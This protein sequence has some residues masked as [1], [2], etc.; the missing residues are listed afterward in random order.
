MKHPFEWLPVS[1][2]KPVFIVLLIVTLFIT[3]WT[4]L[5]NAPLNNRDAPL[6]IISYEFAFT[7]DNARGIITSWKCTGKLYAGISLGLDFI[8]IAG[9]M[10]TIGLGCILAARF[11][12]QKI[13]FLYST[14]IL[15]SWMQLVAGFLDCIE[16]AALLQVLLGSKLQIL[17][18]VAFFCAGPK[19]T[20][21]MIGLSYILIGIIV[22]ILSKRDMQNIEKSQVPG[23]RT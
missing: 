21:V 11:F 1:T 19:F 4:F 20:I 3:V 16:N 17:P 5:L 10:L 22:F 14:G 9:Y 18:V 23:K 7:L 8:F 6:G 12:Y 13:Q 15:L 2:Q